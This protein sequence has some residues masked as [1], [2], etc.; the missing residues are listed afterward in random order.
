MKNSAAKTLG[1]ESARLVTELHERGK[2][3]SSHA[4]IEAITVL[5]PKSARNFVAS[6]V[7]PGQPQSTGDVG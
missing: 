1:P 7:R 4:D 2:I 3:L 5:Q 6:P